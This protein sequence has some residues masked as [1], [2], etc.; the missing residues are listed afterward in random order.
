V[1]LATGAVIGTLFERGQSV[2]EFLGATVNC[3]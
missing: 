1:L 2:C 3:G